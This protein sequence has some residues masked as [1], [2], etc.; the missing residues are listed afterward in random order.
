MIIS[1]VLFDLDNTLVN[2]KLAFEEFTNRLIDKY[3]TI[4]TPSERSE[5][6]LYI[7]EADKDGYRSKKELYQELLE[8]LKWNKETRIDELLDFWFSEFFK[9]TVLM[10]GAIE[11][12]SFLRSK[13][14]KLGLITNGSIH[15]QNAKIDQ[16]GI[17]QYFD[18]IVVSD[19][20]QIKKP[21]SRIFDI[22]LK[23][24][25]VEPETSIYVGDHPVNDIKGALDAGLKTVWLKGFRDWDVKEVK[26]HYT[27]SDLRELMKMFESS[28]E[29]SRNF[30]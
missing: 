3:I 7:R 8:K 10:D 25:N 28:S 13:E 19:E 14:M 16:V 12:I 21:D 2:R 11:V 17:R 23:R 22:A 9:C 6:I 20:V 18:T 26:P 5:V 15:S 27:V 29:T 24:L 4:T 1:A 30:R